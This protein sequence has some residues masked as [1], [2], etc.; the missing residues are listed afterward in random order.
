MKLFAKLPSMRPNIVC[1]R[2]DRRHRPD[3]Q[4]TDT[5]TVNNSFK[6]VRTVEQTIA[7]RH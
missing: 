1:E 3:I 7:A 2:P 6:L 4:R 5:E